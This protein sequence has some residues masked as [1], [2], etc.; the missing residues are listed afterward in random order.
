MS[1]LLSKSLKSPRLWHVAHCLAVSR[2]NDRYNR[3]SEDGIGPSSPHFSLSSPS[4]SP[5]PIEDA[6]RVGRER[7]QGRVVRVQ[8][9]STPYT[10]PELC[11]YTGYAVYGTVPGANASPVYHSAPPVVG[12]PPVYPQPPGL[13]MQPPHTVPA[14]GAGYGTSRVA[15]SRVRHNR[16]HTVSYGLSSRPG[17]PPYDETYAYGTHRH[18]RRHSSSLDAAHGG[19]LPVPLPI[20]KVETDRKAQQV[21]QGGT[22][23][24]EDSGRRPSP[25]FRGTN[26]TSRQPSAADPSA[27]PP[28]TLETSLRKKGSPSSP[29][30]LPDRPGPQASALH[31]PTGSMPSRLPLR[32][33]VPIPPAPWTTG[34][35]IH[36]S[37]SAHADGPAHWRGGTAATGL[38]SASLGWPSPHDD[39]AP[40]IAVEAGT[41]RSHH[42]NHQGRSYTPSSDEDDD[43]D[44]TARLIRPSPSPPPQPR[45]DDSRSPLAESSPGSRTI[46]VVPPPQGPVVY[47]PT[48]PKQFAPLFQPEYGVPQD[49]VVQPK[50]AYPSGRSPYA[51]T[52]YVPH[53]FSYSPPPSPPNSYYGMRSRTPSTPPISL[54]VF[55]GADF[56]ILKV[57]GWWDDAQL[58]VELKRKYDELR[59]LRRKWFSL[60]GVRS[61]V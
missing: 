47:P 56:R 40:A 42:A 38:P 54:K 50:Q 7:R 55:R 36:R 35:S 25:H 20:P 29:A 31:S 15:P 3:Y 26:T 37:Q 57:M 53:A 23:D 32:E 34:P 61:V 8:T 24:T 14:Y 11:S 2:H 60:R 44:E 43:D 5:R 39:A 52:S 9:T 45:Y 4:F 17:T 19:H 1:P 30:T 33:P 13:T 21:G 18:H 58:L 16:H 46:I 27:D 41:S 49:T 10:R 6:A 51:S 28:A 22:R 48:I 59:T 12:A